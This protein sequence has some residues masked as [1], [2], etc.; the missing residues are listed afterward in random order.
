M[1]ADVYGQQATDGYV[2]V[3]W[4][5]MIVFGMNQSW[6]GPEFL[7]MT[8]RTCTPYKLVIERRLLQRWEIYQY[9]EAFRRSDWTKPYLIDDNGRHHR[10]MVISEFLEQE[11]TKSPDI[12][13]IE[14][15]W[16]ILK[17]WLTDR[18]NQADKWWANWSMQEWNW[19]PR[20]QLWASKNDAKELS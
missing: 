15:A 10:A 2:T 6:Y 1:D 16:N 8:I 19:I 11:R 17:R 3:L 9:C 5:S 14:D 7:M 13:L 4:W 18:V 20:T 12:K